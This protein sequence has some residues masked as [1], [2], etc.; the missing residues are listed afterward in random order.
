MKY[1]FYL[2]FALSL[3]SYSTL[4]QD[5]FK[6]TKNGEKPRFFNRSELSYSFGLNPTFNGQSTN[7]FR[8]KTV[9]GFAYPQYGFGIGIENGSFKSANGSGGANFNT[10]AFTGNIHV[11]A[12]PFEY[13]GLNLFIKGGVGYAPKFFGYAK[14][15]TYDGGAGVIIHTKKGRKYYIEALYDYQELSDYILNNSKLEI[16][17]LGIGI[18]TWF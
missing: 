7:A 5:N 1:T 3:S 12:K 8:I 14:G 4:A 17:T 18:G 11:L 16:K 15:F 2:L 10:I 6:S 13:D 9:F